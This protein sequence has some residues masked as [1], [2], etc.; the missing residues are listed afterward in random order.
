M[1][2]NALKYTKT[3]RYF[4]QEYKALTKEVLSHLTKTMPESRQHEVVAY[5]N[6]QTF[7]DLDVLVELKSNTKQKLAS[8]LV[9]LGVH[10]V[11]KNGPVWS[12]GYRDFQVDFLFQ[13]T[14]NYDVARQYFAFNDLG[15]FVGR[16]AKNL[17]FKYGHAGLEFRLMDGTHLV[18][19]LV[20]TKDPKK[21]LEFL[22]YDSNRFAKG[23]KEMTDVFEYASST[24]Y[25]NP[26]DY[27]L[28]NRNT[29]D[30][31][32]DGKRKSYMEFLQ[33]LKHYKAN[34]RSD[35]P[36]KS[37]MLLLAKNRFPDFEKRLSTAV[38]RLSVKK[39]L[40][41]K[42]NGKVVGEL[43]GLSSR[44]LGKFMEVLKNDFSTKE[45]FEVFV[46]TS[47]QVHLS[48]WVVSHFKKM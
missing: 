29:K 9:D 23:F 10:E 47:T 27:L 36:L 41:A 11:V 21:A 45:D 7:G 35:R 37:E 34:K 4:R 22:G 3:R 16:V 26:D 20:V 14:E 12:V 48:K 32:R 46:L 6:K 30:R 33:W 8:L 13:S 31:R 40:K 19:T 38:D 25:F 28:Q 17:G 44:G 18:E 1:G 24:K 2:G 39:A 42:F 5:F 43:T 15:N